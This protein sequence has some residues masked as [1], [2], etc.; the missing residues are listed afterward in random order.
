MGLDV[1][2]LALG[3]WKGILNPGPHL[4]D[5]PVNVFIAGIQSTAFWCLA[6]N[7]TELLDRM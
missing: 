4:A 3:L 7:T 1:S 6:H 2:E 5:D